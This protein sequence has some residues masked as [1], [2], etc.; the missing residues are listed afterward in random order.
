MCPSGLLITPLFVTFGANRYTPNDPVVICPS[1]RTAP[2]VALPWK[3][4]RPFKKSVS[5]R[6]SEDAMSPFT[7]TCAVGPNHTP[8]GLITITDPFA[9]SDPRKWLGSPP[10]TRLRA[11]EL[12]DG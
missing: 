5:V 2:F 8:F 7:F 9:M 1:F 12:I 11:M 6:L 3:A 10:P 4:Y